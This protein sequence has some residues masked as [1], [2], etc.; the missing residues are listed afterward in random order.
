[1]PV[2]DIRE[3]IEAPPDKVWDL[4]CDI[5]RGPEWITVMLETLYVSE[6]WIQKGSVYRELSKV[7]PSKSVTEWTITAFDPGHSQVH[8]THEKTL[9]VTLTI[10]VE[11]D[12]AGTMLSHH[13][14]Y[15]MMPV[16]RPLGW[17]LEQ[18]FAKRLMDKQLRLS[19]HNAK[20]I[21]ES[22]G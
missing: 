12:G 17:V 3:H 15:K 8:E 10:T 11:P 9:K 18:V 16:F 2:V 21:L 22:G 19:V 6:D 4:M 13:T 5:K 1:M 7:G 20:R 14:E